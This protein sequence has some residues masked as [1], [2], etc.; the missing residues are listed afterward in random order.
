LRRL[1]RCR[2]SI[3]SQSIKK[4]HGP[5]VSCLVVKKEWL[6]TSN[7]Q[8]SR[9]SGARSSP[10]AY[11][12]LLRVARTAVGAPDEGPAGAQCKRPRPLAASRGVV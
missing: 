8:V 12:R 2:A 10:T 1:L 7:R 5:P 6:N 9:A 11:R 3:V 4:S